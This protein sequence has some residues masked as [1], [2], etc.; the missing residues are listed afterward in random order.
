MLKISWK[1]T[2]LETSFQSHPR[3][4]GNRWTSTEGTGCL[5]ARW[6]TSGKSHNSAPGNPDQLDLPLWSQWRWNPETRPPPQ[7]HALGSMEKRKSPKHCWSCECLWHKFHTLWFWWWHHSPLQASS[8]SSTP[9]SLHPSPWQPWQE[10]SQEETFWVTQ[11][12]L[13][14]QGPRENLE[15]RSHTG[16]ES[17]HQELILQD[18]QCLL[19][20]QTFPPRLTDFILI[21]PLS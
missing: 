21:L 8:H 4:Y 9:S 20:L 12:T 14:T 17:T 7:S 5:V 19:I 6:C 16:Q 2:S 10:P 1:K 18:R 13:D 11:P 15:P 3:P